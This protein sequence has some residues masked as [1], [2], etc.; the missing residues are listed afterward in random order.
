MGLRDFFNN[1]AAGSKSNIADQEEIKVNNDNK[2]EA[3][4]TYKEVNLQEIPNKITFF[5]WYDSFLKDKELR[6]IVHNVNTRYE[7]GNLVLMQQGYDAALQYLKYNKQMLYAFPFGV[8][9]TAGGYIDEE[10]YNDSIELFNEEPETFGKNVWQLVDDF[11]LLD[12]LRSAIQSLGYNVEDVAE[13]VIEFLKYDYCLAMYYKYKDAFK[14]S[15]PAEKI[16]RFAPHDF[17]TG[18]AYTNFEDLMSLRHNEYYINYDILAFYAFK[19]NS[20]GDDIDFKDLEELF[21]QAREF[22]I[23]ETQA[24]NEFLM[25]KETDVNDFSTIGQVSADDLLRGDDQPVENNIDIISPYELEELVEQAYLDLGYNALATKK[26]GDQG[27]DVIVQNPDTGIK[28]VVQ[29][30]QYTSK[31]GNKAVQE[32]I[33]GKAFYNAD[34]AIVMTNNYFTESAIELAENTGVILFDRDKLIDFLSKSNDNY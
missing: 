14:I 31:V 1:V 4:K 6:N 27:A 10:L 25:T 34:E 29:V 9:I 32:I 16:Y 8:P 19:I 17:T 18:F 22:N 30:K 21:F 23:Q 2:K 7:A 28:T 11:K 15:E 33:A 3:S 24:T 5:K 12:T 26:S 20:Y 13:I